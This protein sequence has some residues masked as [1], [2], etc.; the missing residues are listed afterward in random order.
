MF[1]IFQKCEF[2]KRNPVKEKSKIKGNQV[3]PVLVL[4]SRQTIRIRPYTKVAM[5]Q[6]VGHVVP[7]NAPR[8]HIWTYPIVI[9]WESCQSSYL[10]QPNHSNTFTYDLSVNS[11]LP[12]VFSYA[13]YAQWL[14]AI[15]CISAN[16]Y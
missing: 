4:S 13:L 12:I 2:L 5:R 10:Y 8:I 16:V 7:R 3:S 15:G 1:I 6:C 9:V 14:F 11:Q